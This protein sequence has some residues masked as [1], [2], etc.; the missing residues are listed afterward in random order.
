V[1]NF[2]SLGVVGVVPCIEDGHPWLRDEVWKWTLGCQLERC[3]Y[4]GARD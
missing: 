3:V 2:G 4:K 1:S